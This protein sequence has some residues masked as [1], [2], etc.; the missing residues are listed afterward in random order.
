LCSER[1]TYTIRRSDRITLI[2]ISATTDDPGVATDAITGTNLDDKDLDQLKKLFA[3]DVGTGKGQPSLI[4][5][6][7]KN[8]PQPKA[9]VTA[10]T[11]KLIAGGKLTVTFNLKKSENGKDTITKTSGPV[12][13]LIEAATPLFTVSFGLGFSNA[14]TPT[15]AIVKTPTIVTF[16]KDG[17]TQQAFQQVVLLQ[18]NDE[19]FQPI[20][21]LMAF[22]NFRMRNQ[23]YASVG[24][25]VNQK[26][27]ESPLAGVTY[28]LPL[29]ERRGLN[30]TGGVHFSRELKIAPGSGWS[31]GQLVDPTI[32][33]T[34]ADIADD[35][36][37]ALSTQLRIHCRF[38][39]EGA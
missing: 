35:A 20:Q 27:F 6:P 9:D 26:V 29:G 23:W 32:G 22:V 10:V 28:R 38:L 36:R 5:P 17:E 37:V 18:D 14:P 12:T 1:Y 34:V 11:D 21:S 15:V 19:H 16:E 31:D 25:Q 2:V 8:L 7:S 13:F 4:G 24:V 3:G 30:F 33:L 39:N